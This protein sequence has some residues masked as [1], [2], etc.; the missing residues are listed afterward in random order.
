MFESDTIRLSEGRQKAV[1]EEL[2]RVLDSAAFRNSKRCREFLEYIVEHTI[3]GATATLKERSI[4]IE[5]FHRPPDFDTSQHT[6]VRVTANE[7]RKKLAQYYL[8]QN[9]CCGAVRIELPPGSYSAE[10]K[11]QNEAEAAVTPATPA[12][13]SSPRE[14]AATVL[15]A[16][17]P[18][19]PIRPA[20]RPPWRMASAVATAMCILLIAGGLSWWALRNPKHIAAEATSSAAIR[21]IAA[22]ASNSAEL[23]IL[24]G[25]ANPYIDRSGRVWSPDRFFFGGATI[26]RP[27]ERIFRTLD[28]DIYRHIRQGDFQYDIPLEAGSYEMHLH[29]A[30]TGLADF[31]SAESSGEGQRLF[32]VSANSRLILNVFDVLADAAGANIADE[33]VF[34]DISP[35]PDGKLHLSFT[36]MRSTAMVSGIELLPMSD[37]KVAP[38]RIRAGWPGSWQDSAGEQWRAD[39]YF[40]GGNALV[41]TTNPVR[42]SDSVTP[43][44][45]LYTSERWG[46]F[47]YALPVANGRYRITLRFCEGHYGR[48]NTGVGGRGSRVFDVYCNGV[49]LLDHFDIFKEAGGEGRPVVRSF[50]GIRP[51]AQGKIVLTFVPVVGMA[52]VNGIEVVED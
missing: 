19:A 51:N 30:E 15:D 35:G 49:T 37:G 21:P 45:A 20:S 5:L 43:D 25:S 2:R 31:I 28:P 48:R 42:G 17:T 22:G 1:R 34:R 18:L 8:A 32:R 4:G 38:L 47:S 13:Q 33:R 11:W 44:M 24:V 23:R 40:L 9:P 16:A 26:V 29:F 10:F 39:S 27:S 6:I 12:P 3:S 41:R 36:S 50:S 14:I 7:V 46:H 52:C